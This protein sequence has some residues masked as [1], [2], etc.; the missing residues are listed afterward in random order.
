MSVYP[1]LARRTFNKKIGYGQPVQATGICI[2]VMSLLSGTSCGL[3][4]YI[5]RQRPFIFSPWLPT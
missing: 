1:P 5:S 4:R 3:L 2:S